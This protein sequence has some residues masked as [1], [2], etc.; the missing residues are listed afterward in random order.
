MIS[1][2]ETCPREPIPSISNVEVKVG[3]RRLVA[4]EAGPLLG[5]LSYAS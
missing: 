2:S 3:N 5:L 4:A 1:I